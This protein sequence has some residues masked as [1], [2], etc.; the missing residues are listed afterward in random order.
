[1]YYLGEEYEGVYFTKREGECLVY[2]LEGNTIV[3][4]AKILG[5]SSRTVE[6]YVKNMKMKIGVTTK[7]QL[8]EKIKIT[9]FLKN[10]HFNTINRVRMAQPE[11]DRAN[12]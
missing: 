10:Y 4:T 1:M 3:A 11:E 7:F 9:D 6:F 2:M 12:S 5:L 8:L